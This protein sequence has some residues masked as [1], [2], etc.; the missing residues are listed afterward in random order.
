MWVLARFGF[1][2]LVF[3]FRFFGRRQGVERSALFR[4]TRRVILTKKSKF[5]DGLRVWWGLALKTPLVFSLTREGVGD[6]VFK[7]LGV[8]TE[9]QTGDEEFDRKI[10]VAGDHPA[11]RKLLSED[12]AL[13]QRILALFRKAAK[14]IFC[15]G[16]H[17]WVEAADDG[18]ASDAEIQE[19]HGI[20]LAVKHAS[21]ARGHWLL[22]PFLWTAVAI[23]ALVWSI[24]LYGVPAF[25][26]QMYYQEVLGQSRRYFDFWAL[27]KPGLLVAGAAFVV[28]FCLIILLL[29]GSSRGH[30]ILVESFL[31]LLVG[32]PLSAMHAVSD[33]NIQRDTSPEQVLEYRVVEKFST[34]STGRG[35]RVRSY[36]LKL[37]PVTVGAPPMRGTLSVNLSTYNAAREGG[38]VNFT[39]RAGR[40]HVPWI[41]RVEVR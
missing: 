34:R 26:E 18:D 40:L 12:A 21:P 38:A 23:E 3:L 6:R 15:D 28:L 16:R 33:F 31:V 37:E 1:A 5:G 11:L 29:R 2:G 4:D 20:Y 27:T 19:L 14:R 7:F 9:V 22:D 35:H 17:L 30:R 39:S 32:L 25:V 13:R 8:S 10:Y 41:T 36:H 24:A